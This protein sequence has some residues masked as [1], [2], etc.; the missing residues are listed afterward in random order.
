M[1]ENNNDKIIKYK[2]QK[3][4]KIMIIILSLV[5]IVLEVLALFKVIDMIWG[6][7]VFVIIYILK[8]MF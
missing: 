6:C 7:L 2:R 4:K 5:V 8:K 3:A 1:A